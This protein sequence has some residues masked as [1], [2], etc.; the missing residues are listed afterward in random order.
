MSAQ[1]L[2]LA[3]LRLSSGCFVAQVLLPVLLGFPLGAAP[4]GSKG[5]G[6]LFV[7]SSLRP[8]RASL[9]ALRVNSFFSLAHKGIPNRE[10]PINYL[11]V[12]K[13][14]GIQRNT[15]SLQRSGNNQ[16]VINVVAVC[17]RKLQRCF[18]Y[19]NA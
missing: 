1:S 11:P 5:A 18:V 9:G 8:R 12:L 13:V 2:D 15:P 16:R 14:F 19:F 3:L 6:F 17:L 4:F 10:P 7:F